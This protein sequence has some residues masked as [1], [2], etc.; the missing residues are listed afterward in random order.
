MFI[1][2]PWYNGVLGD[3]LWHCCIG[4][5]SWCSPCEI[6]LCEITIYS[7][8][9][10][11]CHIPMWNKLT[12]WNIFHCY[13]YVSYMYCKLS[14][15]F[16]K[17]PFWISKSTRNG[18]FSVAILKYQRVIFASF[19]DVSDH[20]WYSRFTIHSLSCQLWMVNINISSWWIVT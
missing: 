5:N 20:Q 19:V 10:V 2:H 1:C 13:T 14:Y 16:V 8:S 11:N 17:S 6:Y 15:T 18:V 4:V 12:M 9:I 3:G 7:Y